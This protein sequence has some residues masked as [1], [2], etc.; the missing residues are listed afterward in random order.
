MPDDNYSWLL[1][2]GILILAFLWYILK[3]VFLWVARNMW[4]IATIVSI[5]WSICMVFVYGKHVEYVRSERESAELMKRSAKEAAER[6][7]YVTKMKEKG[8]SLYNSPF[9]G[10]RWGT[11]AQIAQWQDEDEARSLPRRVLKAIKEF[12]PSRRWK[13]EE[14]YQGELQ[15]YLRTHFPNSKVEVQ[16]GRSRPDIVIEDIAIEV[17]GP[18]LSK[19]LQ[20]IADKAMRYAKHFDFLIVVL[21]RV[22]AHPRMYSEWKD[23]LKSQYPDVEVVRI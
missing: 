18:T 19:D 6:K 4:L 13:T 7:R 17:K 14:G 11:K 10:E 16:R 1:V 15:G 9:V 21:F 5:F 12:E 22:Q 2:A 3:Q 8:L 20:T 23:A